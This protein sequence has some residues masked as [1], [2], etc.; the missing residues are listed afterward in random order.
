LIPSLRGRCKAS[1]APERPSAALRAAAAL[2]GLLALPIGRLVRAFLRRPINE[3]ASALGVT[4]HLRL[5]FGYLFNRHLAAW[6]GFVV[7]LNFIYPAPDRM[8]MLI[9]YP[10]LGFSLGCPPNAPFP[11]LQSHPE[12]FLR[13]A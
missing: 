10:W 5:G 3:P 9:P 13:L 2:G 4:G 6:R 7:N 12:V 11:S 1:M 8:G